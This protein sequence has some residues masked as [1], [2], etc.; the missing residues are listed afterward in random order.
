MNVVIRRALSLFILAALSAA[1]QARADEPKRPQPVAKLEL[2]A[3]DSVVF[4]GDSI[5][6]QCLY[7]QY[8]EDYFYT[9]FPKTRARFHNAGVGG[10][11]AWDAL[12][13][14]DRDVAAY[15]P[16]YV[17]V[18]L[19]MN[20]GSYQPFNQSVFDAYQKDMT[21]LIGRLK[22]IGAT[23]VLMTPTMYDARA[24][25]IGGRQAPPETVSLYNSVL[26][27]YGGWLRDVAVES[28]FGFVDM[29][30]PLNNL[31]LEQR[32]SNADFTIIHDAVHPEAPGQLIMAFAVLTNMN[33]PRAVSSIQISKP[34]AGVTSIQ[35]AGGALSA[36]AADENSISFAWV[37]ECLPFVVPE[38]AALGANMVQLGDRLS[39]ETL[40]V[41]A[42]TP[43]TYQLSIDD[44]AIGQYSAGQLAEGISFE[45][46]ANTPQH[47]QAAEVAELNKQRNSGPVHA[48]RDVWRD[49][50]ALAR[51]RQQ[52]SQD[53]QNEALSKQVSDL[54]AKLANMETTIA[55]QE[56][57][58][59]EMEDKIFQ[60]NQPQPHKYSIT[61]VA[62]G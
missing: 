34:G 4:L 30:S 21:E 22:G 38:E 14:F 19:G 58:A 7:T 35:T 49:F 37:A 18:L 57:A 1:A 3:G 27:Y 16:K 9:R 12:Q 41:Q 32:K 61:R 29:Y 25:R 8:V 6:H 26:A 2:S 17:T 36:L 24:A 28:G 50:Q 11:K 46:N 31:T 5:T 60:I 42:L 10:A 44:Q 33:V 59:A 52:L 51:T 20:D 47:R 39:R 54:E 13:R 55:E 15:K 62:G 23:P 53:T 45:N 56:K 48:L 40:Q 43:G